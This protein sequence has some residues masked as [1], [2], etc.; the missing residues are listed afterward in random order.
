MDSYK[1]LRYGVV[2]CSVFICTTVISF[3]LDEKSKAVTFNE[4][5]YAEKIKDEITGGVTEAVLHD[6]TRVDI[7][8]ETHAYEVDWAKSG[9]HFEAIGQALYYAIVTEKKPGIYLLVKDRNTDMKY[10]YRT[11]IVCAKYDISLH[12]YFVE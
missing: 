7:L 8:T 9:K 10:V 4:V 11:A 2:V 5:Y 1:L 3:A 12:V 6:R